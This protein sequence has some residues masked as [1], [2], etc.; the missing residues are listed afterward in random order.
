MKKL[1]KSVFSLVLALML[2]F[3]LGTSAF[4]EEYDIDIG[5]ITVNA[6]ESG[7]TVSQVNGVTDQVQT[8]DTVIK[9][10]SGNS[11]GNT[12][13]IN[14][15]EG[16]KAN[17]TLD[18]VNIDTSSQANGGAAISVTG[19]GDTNIELSGE[20]TVK[21]AANHAGIEKNGDI[22]QT[23]TLTITD[24]D[25]DGSL[26]ATGGSGGAGIGGGYVGEGEDPEYSG[27]NIKITGGTII[28]NGGNGDGTRGSGGAGIGGSK[29][30]AG[31]NIEISGGDV[32]AN[33]GKN[34]DFAGGA[35]IGGGHHG[36]GSKITISGGKVTATGGGAGGA[37]IGGGNSAN[38]DGITITNGEVTATG[39][40][41]ASANKST[42]AGI[43]GGNR[44][45]GKNISISGGNVTAKGG[46]LAGAD[47]ATGGAGIGGGS[48]G[49]AESVTISGDSTV[50]ATGGYGAAGIGG[51][52]SIYSGENGTCENVTVSGNANVTATAGDAYIVNGKTIVNAGASIGSG[53]DPDNEATRVE[54]DTKD[55]SEKGNLTENSYEPPKPSE[56]TKPSE[57]AEPDNDTSSEGDTSS[58]DS[59]TDVITVD[60]A[61]LSAQYYVVEGEE[62]AWLIGSADGLSFKLSS[63]KVQ[64]VLIDGEEVEFEL[65]ANGEIVISYEALEALEAGEHEIEFIFADGSCK[66]AFMVK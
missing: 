53:G 45:D 11:T 66:T 50:N 13:T 58:S 12:V 17:V 2:V 35:G 16:A 29:Y 15:E 64:K 5:A 60:T 56:P 43:G 3:S 4:A 22:N 37:G 41:S 6:G 32:T 40:A 19:K 42:G 20:N 54:A 31:K 24:K 14:A 9:S 63:D 18:G 62:Q 34:S 26:T 10:S 46:S 57:P 48:R 27:E 30:A 21:S 23:G 59:S 8:T 55:L 61:P 1:L 28:A 47:Y 52:S 49:N 7:Q 25:N 33:G 39:G 51:G 44:A 65:N 36:E 38:G